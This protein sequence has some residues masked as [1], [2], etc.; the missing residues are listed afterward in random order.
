MS[1]TTRTASA[2]AC[3][4]LVALTGCSPNPTA[5]SAPTPRKQRAAPAGPT[6]PTHV[7]IPSL[8]I[9]SPVTE[10]GL[11]EDRTVQVPPADQPMTTGWY[12][13]SSVPGDVGAAVLIGHNETRH[14]DAVFHDL[15]KIREGADITVEDTEGTTLH[16]TVTATEAVKKNAFPSQK[17]YGPTDDRALRLI[18]CDGAYDSDGHTV[19]NLIV[20]ATLSAQAPRGRP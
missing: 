11:N 14:G 12:T 17:V 8:G 2:L 13:G 10:L 9:S 4:T 18:T 3:A 16:F 6:N 1:R 5:D 15:K 19:D 7:T 20:Y